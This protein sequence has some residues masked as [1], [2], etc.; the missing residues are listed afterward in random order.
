MRIALDAPAGDGDKALNEKIKVQQG[1]DLANRA[2]EALNAIMPPPPQPAA[3]PPQG[4]PAIEPNTF[5]PQNVTPPPQPSPP[6]KLKRT[7]EMFSEGEYKPLKTGRKKMMTAED[8]KRLYP[9]F[10]AQVRQDLA[11]RQA[12]QGPQLDPIDLNMLDELGPLDAP[13]ESPFS[14]P[15]SSPGYT[16]GSS[17]GYGSDS[18]YES[19]G[20]EY[21]PNSSP[22]VNT[23]S[24]KKRDEFTERIELMKELQT[25]KPILENNSAILSTNPRARGAISSDSDSDPDLSFVDL[26][27]AP[28]KDP[29]EQAKWDAAMAK[30][31]GILQKPTEEDEYSDTAAAL[32]SGGIPEDVENMEDVINYMSSDIDDTVEM[33]TMFTDETED[34]RN[35]YQEQAQGVPEPPAAVSPTIQPQSPVVVPPQSPASDDE[36]KVVFANALETT[37]TRLKKRGSN[38]MMPFSGRKVEKAPTPPLRQSARIAARNPISIITNKTRGKPK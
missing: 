10:A 15:A 18:G 25:M 5:S 11:R 19:S 12:E 23:P 21:S 35:A 34:I 6:R 37:F 1:P 14:S 13:A 36:N 26:L 33:L 9:E 17:S 16:S 20:S 3:P 22:N 29:N 4:T 7:R 38:P 8:R 24:P 27:N 2:R 32:N 30:F 31:S 28:L